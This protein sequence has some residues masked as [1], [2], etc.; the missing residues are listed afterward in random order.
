MSKLAIKGG[1]PIR[2]KLFPFYSVIGKE[3]IS[4]S[5]RVL[6]SGIL[7]K[8]LGS[9]DKDFYGGKEVRKFESEWAKYFK[10]KHAMAVNSCTSGI[11]CAI[12]AA[13]IG[14]GDEVIVTPYTLPA[15]VTLV[16]LYGAIPVFA[17]IEHEYFCLDPESVKKKITKR[18][19]AII[20]VDLFG[21]PY[22]ADAINKIAKKN[23]LIVIEDCAQA[24][25]VKYKEKYA[26]T[27]GDIGIYSLNYHKH[28][29]TGE[30]GV[31]VTNNDR[32]AERVRLVRNHADAVI[33]EKGQT[34]D[35]DNMIG[36]N[37]RL[38][39]I[40]AAIGRTQLKKLKK[41]V[42][43]RVKNCRYLAKEISKI[44]GLYSPRIRPYAQH[45]YY[46]QPF[47]YNEKIIGVARD[48]FVEAVKAELA[49]TRLRES[50][51]V[52]ISCGGAKPL[53]LLPLFQKR[54]AIGKKGYPF[55]SKD[56]K[57]KV[58]YEK[59]LCPVTEKLKEKEMIIHELMNPP[60]T[61]AD[62]DD[63]VKAFKKVYQY[64][65]ELK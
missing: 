5:T 8:Y 11:H 59:G 61:R 14:P 56:F 51:G 2:K 36:F 6:K 4:A 1:K 23:N 46:V 29:H 52:R 12:A 34:D 7:S 13:G 60:M 63:F 28:I 15:S 55:K 22:N 3:E 38:T 64:R 9:W 58:S 41:L 35:L 42:S 49:P 53:Y 40:Q 65:N 47:L 18:T 31:V 10:V 24:P 27:L 30:G 33:S 20:V 25:G 26:G 50:E 54:I 17:D 21:Q 39:E 43:Q 57:V 16:L 48:K 19:K 37:F 45:A 32:L 62:L 44:P